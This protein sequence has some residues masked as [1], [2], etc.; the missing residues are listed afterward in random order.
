M[1]ESDNAIVL[2]RKI[3]R[4]HGRVG[5]RAAVAHCKTYVLQIP[6]QSQAQRGGT[7]TSANPGPELLKPHSLKRQASYTILRCL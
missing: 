5:Y 7:H 6:I 1:R 3:L 2:T 4:H